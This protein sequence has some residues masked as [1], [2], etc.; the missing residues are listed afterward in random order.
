MAIRFHV[1][2]IKFVWKHKRLLASWIKDATLAEDRLVGA[3]NVI[4]CSDE[5]LLAMNRQYLNH[6]Y[7]TDIITFDYSSEGV[8]SGDLYISLERTHDNAA[9]A[10]VSAYNELYRV[11]IHGVMHLCGYGDKKTQQRTL[12]REKEDFFLKR[13]AL[14]LS[15]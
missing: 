1:E 10:G 2:D 11:V 6:D 13:L 12:M 8:I 3:I 4:L 5:Y 14:E 15:F 7:Y 9:I